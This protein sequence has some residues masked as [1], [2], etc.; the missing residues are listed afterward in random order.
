MSAKTVASEVARQHAGSFDLL[1]DLSY[2]H[3]TDM[4]RLQ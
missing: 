3:L 2:S 1:L 4:L